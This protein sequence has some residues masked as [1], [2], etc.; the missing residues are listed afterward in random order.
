M[1]D[2]IKA[3]TRIFTSP[4]KLIIGILFTLPIPLISWFTNIMAEGYAYTCGASASASDY[5]LP[6]WNEPVWLWIKGFVGALIGIIYGI[7]SFIL[8]LLVSFQFFKDFVGNQSKTE[9]MIIQHPIQVI[10]T[11]GTGIIFV[12]LLTLLG[13]YLVPIA[14]IRWIRT[15]KFRESFNLEYILKAAFRPSYFLAFLVSYI[16]GLSVIIV[17]NL[18]LPTRI[19]SADFVITWQLLLQ[20][21]ASVIITGII[22]FVVNVFSYTLYGNV[23]EDFEKKESDEFSP[24]AKF[25]PA[26]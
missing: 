19:L 8:M 2:Y 12:F 9:L 22:N 11:Y 26:V 17:I 6:K 18:L 16:A 3:F 14:I 10:S 21:S 23:L 20:L 7:P 5:S 13:A 1:A 4:K 24:A 15:E 25:N